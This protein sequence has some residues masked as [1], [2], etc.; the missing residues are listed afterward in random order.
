MEIII[1]ANAKNFI[2]SLCDYD[3]SSDCSCDCSG[4]CSDCGCDANDYHGDDCMI[5]A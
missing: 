4:D 2:R 1:S 5:G 3:C